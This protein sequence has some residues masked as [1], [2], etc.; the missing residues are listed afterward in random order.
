MNQERIMQVLL[1]PHIS[2]KTAVLADSDRQH[3]FK[4]LPSATKIEIKQAVESLFDVKVDQVRVVNVKGKTK[5]F[6]QRTGKRSDW[7]KAY[8]KLAEGQD[9]DFAGAN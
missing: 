5:R 8:V 7:R 2:E 6:G 9:I 3:V 1:A 4:V